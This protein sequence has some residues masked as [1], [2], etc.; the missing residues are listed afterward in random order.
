MAND[1]KNLKKRA[2]ASVAP[3]VFFVVFLGITS[4][5]IWD[6]QSKVAQTQAYIESEGLEI[7]LNRRLPPPTINTIQITAETLAFVTVTLVGAF[8]VLY[9]TLLTKIHDVSKNL[10]EGDSDVDKRLDEMA[11]SVKTIE[12]VLALIE[13]R[14]ANIK[15]QMDQDRTRSDRR[16]DWVYAQVNDLVR[17]VETRLGYRVRITDMAEPPTGR[18]SMPPPTEGDT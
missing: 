17:F 3:A 13:E 15:S 9:Q 8:W 18:V 2:R 16:D 6:Q 5:G 7:P 10:H 12:G 4:F 1:G 14:M 11:L